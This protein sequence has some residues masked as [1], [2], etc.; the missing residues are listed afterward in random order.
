MSDRDL[1]AV[2]GNGDPGHRT[3]GLEPGLWTFPN[4]MP[5]GQRLVVAVNAEREVAGTYVRTPDQ[6]DREVREAMSGM[7]ETSPSLRVL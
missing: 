2:E 3:Q 5:G 6:T 4:P 7:V 1:E